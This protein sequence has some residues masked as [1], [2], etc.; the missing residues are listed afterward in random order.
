ML[1]RLESG[2]GLNYTGSR[3]ITF[4]V[5]FKDTPA[6]SISADLANGDRYVISAKSR[7]GF[8]IT[9]YTGASI[10]TNPTTIDYV[11]KGYGKEIA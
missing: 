5:A 11:A 3:V 2:S 8:T 1:D 10:S 4:P 6:L 9:T 7:T